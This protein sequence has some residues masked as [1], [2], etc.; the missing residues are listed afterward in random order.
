VTRRFPA[1][2]AIVLLAVALLAAAP[3][4]SAARK[5]PKGFLW[6]V[7]TA[8]F[9]NEMGPGSPSDT[10][11]DWWVWSHDADNIAA[12]HVSG[13]LPENGPSGWTSYAKDVALASRTLHANAYRMSIEWSRIF[14]RSTAGAQSIAELDPLADQSA[15][16]HYRAQLTAIRK[17]GMT[18]FVTLQHFTLPLWIHD[19]IAARNAFKGLGPDDPPPTGFGPAGWLDPQTAVEF[20]KYAGYVAAKLGDLVDYWMPINEPNVV[21]VQ[22]Y[23]NV[24]GVF[25]S[26]FP[27]GV[28]SFRSVLQVLTQQE[29]GNAAAYDAI[30][31]QD[32]TSHVGV[33][34][35]MIA[36]RAAKPGSALDRRGAQHAD[37]L[38]NRAFLDAAIKGEYDANGDGA[39]DASERHPELA[40]RADF[41]GVNYYRAGTVTGLDKPLSAA[42]PAYDFI[43][44][45][46]Y[47]KKDCPSRCSDLGWEI[48]PAGLRDAIRTAAD[49]RL[50]VYVTETGIADA[51]DRLRPMYLRDHAMVIR[52]AV[53]AGA[54]VRGFFHWTLT[55]N[56]EWADGFGP[57]FGL[58]TRARKPRPSAMVFADLRKLR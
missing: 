38:F 40:H 23:L 28:F 39:I 31:K 10:G 4:A 9:Q 30:K 44:K 49:Y 25:A 34:Q 35:H 50:P 1:L 46:Q 26:W 11:S 37:N 22:G 58:F 16:A 56:F 24:A 14:P 54:D 51:R 20:G 32:P 12:H 42:I 43:P 15:L 2:A 19:P 53:R 17:A 3:S 7:A 52:D 41:V 13:D 45:V 27:P 6:G 48:R 36:F 55:D 5:L 33:V 21:A 8:G 47:S 29:L 57:K 18:P